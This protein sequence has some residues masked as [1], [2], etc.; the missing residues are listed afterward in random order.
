M[1]ERE[2]NEAVARKLGTYRSQLIP[3]DYCRSIAAAWE[4]VGHPKYCWQI[5]RCSDNSYFAAASEITESKLHTNYSE[6]K[7]DTAPMAICLAF[8]KL[9]DIVVK[10]DSA[11]KQVSGQG[12]SSSS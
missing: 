3:E 2:I 11:S 1:T 12:K 7:A 9:N 6:A 5:M 8:L 4:V 10:D